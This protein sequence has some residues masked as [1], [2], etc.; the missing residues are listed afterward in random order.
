MRVPGAT[1]SNRRLDATSLPTHGLWVG[2]G[3]AP[4]VRLSTH[5]S[6]L[7][8]FRMEEIWTFHESKG[9]SSVSCLHSGRKLDIVNTFII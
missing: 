1:S 5:F 2:G 3:S 8:H 9:K 7:A 4:S 6:R